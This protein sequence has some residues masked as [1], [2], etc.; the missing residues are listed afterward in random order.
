MTMLVICKSLAG[1]QQELGQC[2]YYNPAKRDNY[3]RNAT[4]SQVKECDSPNLEPGSVNIQSS[5][6][7]FMTYITRTIHSAA[8]DTG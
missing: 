5:L 7:R 3:E 1:E 2:E 8:Y 6:D 4:C